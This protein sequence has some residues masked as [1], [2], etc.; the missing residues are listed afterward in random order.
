[1]DIIGKS[2]TISTIDGSVKTVTRSRVISVKS[3]EIN[4]LK[5]AKTIK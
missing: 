5:K 3:N 2:I 4:T 1:L